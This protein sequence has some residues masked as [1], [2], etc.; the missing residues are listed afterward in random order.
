M[1]RKT[2]AACAAALAV[3]VGITTFAACS[4]NGGDGPGPT[5][6]GQS[7]A[8]AKSLKQT[9]WFSENFGTPLVA[10]TNV[11]PK[12]IEQ[13]KDVRGTVL[14]QDKSSLDGPV[15]WQRVR[16]AALPFSTT[17]G[18][19]KTR[20]DGI[21]GG[22]ARTP[23][24]AALAMVQMTNWAAIA[25]S[26]DAVPMV[27]APGDR[28]RLSPQLPAYERSKNLDNPG[29]L[30][31]QKTII[32]PSLWKAETISDT[33]TRVQVWF[34]PKPGE[35]QGG[36]FDYSVIWADGDWYLTEQTANDVLAIGGRM[37][38]AGQ[39]S[40]APVGWSQW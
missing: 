16:C 29:C 1:K 10:T 13:A 3:A 11:T 14:P 20:A 6:P 26:N 33:V 5:L 18:P 32:R 31:A 38:R 28:A 2:L 27:I 19:T 8:A 9:Q 15:M 35:A 23:L 4:R 34:P 21:Y 39:Y 7:P 17:D 30:A 37:P 36:I 25:G 40:A 12:T 24:G 22:Y